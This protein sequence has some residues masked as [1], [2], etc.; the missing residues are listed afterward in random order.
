MQTK[1]HT[2][3]EGCA[4][5][6]SVDVVTSVTEMETSFEVCSS[7]DLKW[8][9][10]RFMRCT[11]EVFQ[12][13]QD[14]SNEHG[15]FAHFRFCPKQVGERRKCQDPELR[16]SANMMEYR[17]QDENSPNVFLMKELLKLNLKRSDFE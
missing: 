5:E 2:R 14:L 13:R 16:S 9:T 3:I 7:K 11:S 17:G 12:T 4:V 1:S 6:A 8:T 10:D 15:N